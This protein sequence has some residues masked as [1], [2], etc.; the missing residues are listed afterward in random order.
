MRAED[1]LIN[2]AGLV[3]FAGTVALLIAVIV[4]ELG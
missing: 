2:F 1:L 4:H 3:I